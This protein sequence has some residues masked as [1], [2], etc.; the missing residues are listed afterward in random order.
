MFQTEIQCSISFQPLRESRTVPVLMDQDLKSFTVFGKK[1][2]FKTEISVVKA[3]LV[4][5]SICNTVNIYGRR[6]GRE[7]A[8]NSVLILKDK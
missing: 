8:V 4:A 6:E 7:K 5:H 3:V 2:F 1:S